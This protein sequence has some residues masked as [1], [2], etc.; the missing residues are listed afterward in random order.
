MKSADPP[1]SRLMEGVLRDHLRVMPAVVLTGARQTGKS[2]LATEVAQGARTYLTLDNL[3]TLDLALREPARLLSGSGPLTIDEVQRAPDMLLAIKRAIDID[4]I[5]GR[6]LLTGSANLLLMHRVSESLAGRASY[7]SLWPLTRREQLGLGRS[8]RWSELL[9]TAGKDWPDL[10]SAE[11]LPRDDWRAFARRGGF[12]TPSVH[13]GDDTDR[14]RWFEAYVQ[15][16]LERD[17]QTLAAITALSDFRRFMRVAALRLGQLINQTDIGRDAALGQATAHR[18]L[19]LLEAS[20]MVV[21]LPAYAVNRTK[22]LI[23]APKL[24]WC[25]V[26]L[27]LYLAGNIAPEGPHL[28]NLVLSDLLAWRETLTPRSDV[29]YWR[30]SNGEEVDFVVEAGDRLLPIEVK[31]TTQ[32]RFADAAH[33]RTF[34]AEYPERT[35]TAL[36]LHAGERIEWIATN[37]L[38]VPWWCVL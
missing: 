34:C 16:Y 36:L 18:Y 3:A 4:R 17:L 37:V 29:M 8:G 23:K 11:P 7:V 22:R 26:G 21:R 20:Y 14:I 2:T 24:Y 25:D 12:P 33:L 19:N 1:L 5:P 38:A 9:A 35:D 10:L 15:T 31:S 6:F 13:L 28:E 32:P 27:A 30:T